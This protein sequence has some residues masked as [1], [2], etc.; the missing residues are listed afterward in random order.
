MSYIL[1]RMLKTI[2]QGTRRAGHLLARLGWLPLITAVYIVFSTTWSPDALLELGQ[3][4][5]VQTTKPLVCAHTLLENEV[6]EWKIKRSLEL[7]REMGA[8]TIVQFFPWAYFEPSAGQ[9]NWRQA[10]LIV[11]HAVNQ[12]LR[13]IARL[14]LVPEWA[15]PP[16]HENRPTTLNFLPETSFGAFADYAAQLAARY[17][18]AIQHFIVW[19]EPNL[20]FEWGY[21]PVDAA[22]YTRLLQVSYRAIKAANAKALVL[23]GALAPTN[24]VQ[25]SRAGLNENDYLRAMY[26]NGAAPY[27]DAL[28]V[29]SYGATAPADAAPNPDRLNFRRLETQRQIMA[30]AGDAAKPVFI[31]ESGWNDHPRWSGAVRPSQRLQYT[32][33][34]FEYADR[35]WSWVEQVCLWA[36]RFP[37]PLNNYPDNFALV[38]PEFDL[39]P[40]YYALQDYARGWQR[41]ARQWLPRP[42][43]P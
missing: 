39:K 31:T 40:I 26:R 36:F 23:A 17:P 3:A 9:Y 41:G 21:R 15:R 37:A 4:Q 1:L 5:L 12:G 33:N 16:V 32:I 2:W 29:H 19:N 42:E 10:D 7:V 20:S 35:H 43:A 11:R 28:A 25:G 27:F 38:S 22:A 13:I 14:G 24:E 34:A 30:A 18:E 6:H 8:T